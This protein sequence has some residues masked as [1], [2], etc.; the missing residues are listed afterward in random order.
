M[1]RD[2]EEEVSAA[3][4]ALRSGQSKRERVVRPKADAF[5]VVVKTLLL[6]VK[7][8]SVG[9]CACAAMQPSAG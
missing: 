1:R 7:K 9:G 5:V 2:E 8:H 4:H 6:H 3:A